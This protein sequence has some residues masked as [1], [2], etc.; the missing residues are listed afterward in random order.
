MLHLFNNNTYIDFRTRT[1]FKIASKNSSVIGNETG[2]S[3]AGTFAASK[4][5][6]KVL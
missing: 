2:N 6:G 3:G 4:W 5:I 1:V